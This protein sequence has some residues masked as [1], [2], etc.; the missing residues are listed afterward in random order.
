MN[1]Q[2][3]SIGKQTKCKTKLLAIPH[4]YAHLVADMQLATSAPEITLS[5]GRQRS[6]RKP[7][8]PIASVVSGKCVKMHPD[9]LSVSK[10]RDCITTKFQ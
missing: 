9:R 10:V 5:F 3:H 8:V 1:G 7:Q 4:A 2:N 6:A